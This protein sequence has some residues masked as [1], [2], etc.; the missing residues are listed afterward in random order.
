MIWFFERP[1][2]RLRCEIR[3]A[4]MGPGYEL[5]W[6]ANDGRTHVEQSPNP[7]DLMS[8]RRA[9]EHWLKLDGWVRPGRVTPPRKTRPQ[10]EWQKRKS[11]HP[12]SS[13]IH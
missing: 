8:R 5:V 10:S 3:R 2:E 1:G 4:T 12:S 7:E 9:L 6:T 11:E 13:E